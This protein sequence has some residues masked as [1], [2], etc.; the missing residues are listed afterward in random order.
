MGERRGALVMSG[1]VLVIL[2]AGRARRFGGIKSIRLA[3]NWMT[4]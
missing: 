4:K 2:A 3:Y 1:P